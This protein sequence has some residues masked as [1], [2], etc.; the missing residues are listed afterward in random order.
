MLGLRHSDVRPC[1]GYSRPSARS[2]RRRAEGL[3]RPATRPTVFENN[4][5]P[6]SKHANVN[7]M[8]IP[9][10]TSRAKSV[11]GTH[12]DRGGLLLP[13][14]RAGGGGSQYVLWRLPFWL[15]AFCAPPL[16]TKPSW[17]AG[18]LGESV[19]GCKQASARHSPCGRQAATARS[20]RMAI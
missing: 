2:Q 3:L 14:A 18:S 13:C 16:V 1:R 7:V 5:S 6:G 12:G 8:F 10:R 4:T 17:L 19:A 20:F 9:W 15:S 11:P